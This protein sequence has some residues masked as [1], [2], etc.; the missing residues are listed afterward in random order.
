MLSW[1]RRINI[2]RLERVKFRPRQSYAQCGEDLILS[3]IF[4]WLKIDRVRYLDIGAHHPCWLSNTYLLYKQGF[5]GV[6]VEPDPILHKVISKYRPRDLTLNVGVGVGGEKEADFFV[7]TTKTLNTF[8]REEA[9]KYQGYGSQKIE[10]VIRIP[11]V[12]V[13]QIILEYFEACPNF[14]SLDVEGLDLQILQ[15]FDFGR[16][17]PEVFCIETLTY[18][19]NNTEHKVTEIIEFM[20]CNGYFV[21]ADT[22]IN[23]IFIDRNAWAKR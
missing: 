2:Y 21:Y 20:E 13:N 8:S 12:S 16:F 17:R 7:M 9:M 22:Y 14:I 10:E 23:T 15:D 19:E 6:L 5:R 3:H 11:L 4:M 18:T 1:I